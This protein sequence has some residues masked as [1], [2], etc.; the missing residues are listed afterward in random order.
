MLYIAYTTNKEPCI[1]MPLTSGASHF[2]MNDATASFTVNNYL[3]H[4]LVRD[5][6]SGNVSK[7]FQ[8]LT[9]RYYPVT[10]SSTD[11]SVD[12]G[13]TW[14]FSTHGFLDFM[15]NA[16]E[17]LPINTIIS[18]DVGYKEF[19]EISSL[20][21]RRSCAI[22][23][24]PM[25]S[26]RYHKEEYLGKTV[27][28]PY[29][30]LTSMDIHNIIASIIVLPVHRDR[31]TF[32]KSHT[33]IMELIRSISDKYA[34]VPNNNPSDSDRNACYVIKTMNKFKYPGMETE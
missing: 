33:R 25:E 29:V 13:C 20:I 5:L 16:T 26:V 3:I 8:N 27:T 12:N 23:T 19:H 31:V 21:D 34:Y 24:V 10:R 6:I 1:A 15:L 32:I 7:D 14:V 17:N 11:D 30:L 18:S 4:G 9:F 22:V 2:D 28:I